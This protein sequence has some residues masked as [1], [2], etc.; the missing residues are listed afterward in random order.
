[1]CLGFS[2]KIPKCLTIMRNFGSCV[3]FYFFIFFRT[4]KIGY[5]AKTNQGKA[6]NYFTYGVAASLVE[7]D[8]LTGDHQV[9]ESFISRLKLMAKRDY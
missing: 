3:N 7:I 9:C 4:P 6:F 1:M 8:C 5:N 2:R